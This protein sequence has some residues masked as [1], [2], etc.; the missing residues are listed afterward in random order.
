MNH[1]EY[2]D[3]KR[4]E[5]VGV[6]NA[7]LKGDFDLIQGLRRICDLRLEVEEPDNELFTGLRGIESET[8][9]FPIGSMRANLSPEFLRRADAEMQQYLA[10][11][12][13]DI[14]QACQ[15]IVRAFS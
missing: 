5:L 14:L 11:A 7:M 13:D 8:E 6:A 4:R 2:L 1:A 15:E 3:M 12:K 9:F 10:D